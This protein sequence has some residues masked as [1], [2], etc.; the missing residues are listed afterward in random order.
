MGMQGRWLL[1][2]LWVVAGTAQA[3]DEAPAKPLYSCELGN[4]W[5]YDTTRE[6]VRFEGGKTNVTHITG[7]IDKKIV[8]VPLRFGENGKVVLLRSVFKADH[9]YGLDPDQIS[10]GDDQLVEWRQGD[11]Y[12]RGVRVW[13]EGMYSEPIRTYESPLLYLRNA[14]RTGESWT[15]GEQLNMG[16][17]MPTVA[18]LEGVETVTVPAGTFTGCRK[19]AYRVAKVS[20]IIQPLAGATVRITD[21]NVED[22]VWYAKDVGPVK[23]VQVNILIYGNSAAKESSREE[24]TDLLKSFTTAK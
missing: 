5:V 23:E 1:L 10:N 16:L 8:P 19:V 6:V 7:T 12:R 14:A 24:E 22:T 13:F 20:G 18:T 3:A 4:N 11:L 21:G 17:A 9:T 15:V 2:I